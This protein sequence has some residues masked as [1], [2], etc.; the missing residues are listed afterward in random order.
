MNEYRMKQIGEG[1]NYELVAFHNGKEILRETRDTF[2]DAIQ[3]I[4]TLRQ[5]TRVAFDESVP[6]TL[7]NS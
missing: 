2:M 1:P 7:R 3:G 5:A 6:D 4:T